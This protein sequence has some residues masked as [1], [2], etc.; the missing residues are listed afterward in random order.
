MALMY[1]MYL[2]GGS[3][4]AAV[5]EDALTLF[6]S[7]RVWAVS[8]DAPT[9][10][11]LFF[12]MVGEITKDRFFFARES[13][14]GGSFHFFGNSWWKNTNS[15]LKT[16]R[17][18]EYMAAASYHE[19]LVIRHIYKCTHITICNNT[20]EISYH[21]LLVIRH[22]YKCTHITMCNN[23]NEISLLVRI[24]IDNYV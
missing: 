12:G 24:C 14:E 11:L 19:L 1:V 18:E 7:G 10:F 4:S 6:F 20:N 5:S 9:L 2:R 16:T 15:E 17:T 23:T 8:E 13:K 22:I 3:V 21:E